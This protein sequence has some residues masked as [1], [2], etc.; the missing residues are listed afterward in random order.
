VIMVRDT[1]LSLPAQLLVESL[2]ES[3]KLHAG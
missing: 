1:G 2:H 3:A